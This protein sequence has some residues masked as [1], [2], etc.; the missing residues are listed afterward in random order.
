M[1]LLDAARSWN[2]TA[3]EMEAD[4]PAHRYAIAPYRRLIRAVDIAAPPGLVFRWL[5][6]LKVAPYS[7]DCLDNWGRRSPRE[8]TPGAEELAEGQRFMIARIVEF[9]TDRHITGVSLPGATAVFGAMALSYQVTATAGGCRLVAC[10][11]VTAR[12]RAGRLRADLLTIG[13][14]V[15]MRRQLLNLKGLAERAAESQGFTPVRGVA[16]H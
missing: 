2:T 9:E 4:Y 11:D 8:L 7:Y 3:A 12:S 1:R 15:M 6:Q 10:L 16:E 13:D 14:L 5:C